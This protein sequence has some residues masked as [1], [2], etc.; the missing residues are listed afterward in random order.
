MPNL[1]TQPIHLGHGATAL[2]QPDGASAT[3]MLD[4]NVTHGRLSP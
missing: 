2:V 4:L 3:L 1:F